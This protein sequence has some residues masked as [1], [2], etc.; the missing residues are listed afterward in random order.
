MP[1]P[2]LTEMLPALMRAASLWA[3]P[4]LRV[5]MYA[6]SPY[7]VSFATRA[8]LSNSSSSKRVAHTTGPKISSRMTDISGRTWLSTTGRTKKP[9]AGSACSPETISAPCCS[10]ARMYPVTRSSCCADTTGPMKVPGS[11]PGPIFRLRAC[12]T[13][14]S[15]T[16]S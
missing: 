1:A 9:L 13:T 2:P 12:A 6:D 3:M 15:M 10:P 5:Q 8:I 7:E 14:P 16:R 11:T 4:T